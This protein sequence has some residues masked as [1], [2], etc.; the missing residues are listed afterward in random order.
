MGEG[1]VFAVG[2]GFG[3]SVV[4]EGLVLPVVGEGL[5]LPAFGDG[6]GLLGFFCS[7]CHSDIGRLTAYSKSIGTNSTG[8]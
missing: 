3:V 2:E 8:N 5:A 6:F 7:I 1:L 4:G